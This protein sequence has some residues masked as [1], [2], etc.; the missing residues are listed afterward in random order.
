MDE[1]E[2]VRRWA[3]IGVRFEELWRLGAPWPVSRDVTVFPSP[4]LD[5][6]E[7]LEII[8]RVLSR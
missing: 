7:S 3:R 4:D 6:A 5:P 1:I 2:K 8:D